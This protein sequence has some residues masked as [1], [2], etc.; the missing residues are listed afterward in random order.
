MKSFVVAIIIFLS[1]SALSLGL[2]AVADERIDE[3][4]SLTEQIKSEGVQ[5]E[6]S[7]KAIELAMAKWEKSEALFHITINREDMILTK[8]EIAD[9]LGASRASSYADFLVA[10]ERLATSL[11]NI[12]GYTKCRLENIF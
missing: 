10:T 8:K 2:A 7:K 5:A 11:D 3:I 1:V 4:I 6:S 12:K 9:A